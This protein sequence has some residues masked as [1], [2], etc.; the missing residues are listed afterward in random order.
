MHTLYTMYIVLCTQTELKSGATFETMGSIFVRRY[1][2]KL[3]M[4]QS[5]AAIQ[6]AD[7]PQQCP[8]ALASVLHV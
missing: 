7:R 5:A 6:L 4:Q 3:D 2:G 8:T 1:S